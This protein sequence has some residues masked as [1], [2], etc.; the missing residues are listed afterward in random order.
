MPCLIKVDFKRLRLSWWK[1]FKVL[2][3]PVLLFYQRFEYKFGKSLVVYNY[4][5]LN[6]LKRVIHSIKELFGE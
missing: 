1:L 5:T 6:K 3:T 4:G 2:H